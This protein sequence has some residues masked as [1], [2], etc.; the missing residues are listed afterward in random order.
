MYICTLVHAMYQRC[1]TSTV[2]GKTTYWGILQ[3]LRHKL[4][5]HIAVFSWTEHNAD[6][7]SA[8]ILEQSMG[9]SKNRVVVPAPQAT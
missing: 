7:Y 5:D 9:A 4:Q 2:N 8:G 6:L 3:R 1:Y